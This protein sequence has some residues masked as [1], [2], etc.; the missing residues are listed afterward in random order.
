MRYRD[1]LVERN[2][3]SSDAATE[4]DVVDYLAQRNAEALRAWR[5]RQFE[6]ELRRMTGPRAAQHAG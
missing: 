6:Y 5:Q 4:P 2:R 3:R 1:M